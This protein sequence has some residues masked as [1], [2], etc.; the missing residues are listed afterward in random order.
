M[1]PAVL[2]VLLYQILAFLGA[3]AVGQIVTYIAFRRRDLDFKLMYQQDP[4][5]IFSN[6]NRFDKSTHQ[7]AI[8][9]FLS[10]F[11]IALQFIPT[12][13]TKFTS[14][15]SIYYS[16]ITT[17]L[18]RS[19]AISKYNWPTTLP[20][21]NNFV[22]YLANSTATSLQDMTN[23]YIKETLRQNN[24]QNS[25]G[26][27]FTPK[28]SKRFEWDNRQ[29][30]F[31]E[32][33]NGIYANGSL[34][35]QTAT[36]FGNRPG[37][38]EYPSSHTLY[39][40]R[41]SD[42]TNLVSYIPPIH[43]CSVQGAKGYDF[44]CYPIYDNTLSIVLSQRVDGA[45][46]TSLLN[47]NDTIY[48]QMKLFQGT[49]ASSSFGVSIFNHN[50][51][52]MTM[53]IKKTAHITLYSYNKTVILPSDCSKGDRANF[54]NNF[55]DLP[56]NA[57]LCDLI[58]SRNSLNVT[59]RLVQAAGR[60]Y[61]EN[62]VVNTVYTFQDGGMYDE[63]ESIMVDLSVFQATTVEGN[64][65]DKKE[66]MVAYSA[67]NLQLE[68]PSLNGKTATAADLSNDKI[69]TL[70]KALDPSRI[71]QD[72]VDILVGMASMRVRWENGDYADFSLNRSQV[73]EAVETPAWWVIALCALAVIFSI[74]QFCRLVVRQIPEYAED[75]RTLLLLTLER[76]GIIVSQK[77]GA[78]R[79]K[80]MASVGITLNEKERYASNDTDRTAMLSV[81]G[82][83]VII[84]DTTSSVVDSRF[85]QESSLFLN[86][87]Y[88]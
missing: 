12:I 59:T 71:N 44:P 53:A 19:E 57:V 6:Y 46:Q 3:E 20:V 31:L 38:S 37:D 68:S 23:E 70:L 17:P 62:Y 29:K 51:S 55:I 45:Y 28:I 4:L 60:I 56:Y 15:G 49:T 75:L 78:E 8:I 42:P 88:I 13:F 47:S 76:S 2:A 18:A 35:D 1:I 65:L 33:F 66:H 34:A 86:E 64:L 43:G 48:R 73:L 83:P 32:N 39:S 85:I 25:V 87:K 61:L 24:T 77:A 54:T 82:H 27:W 80:K 81:D 14:A 63:G 41:A 67:T 10:F 30:G 5:A 58:N 50:S 74:P 9:I 84:V 79:G 40:C 22:P 36:A 52:H 69:G 11:A 26:H 7:K 21:F 16:P 72:T